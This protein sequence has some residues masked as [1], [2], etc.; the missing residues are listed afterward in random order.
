MVRKILG[1]LA[2]L[3]VGVLV[4]WVIEL[5]GHALYPPPQGADPNQSME[6]ARAYVAGLPAAALVIP[7]VAWL[8]GTLVGSWLAAFVGRAAWPGW[9]V[10]ALM[11]ASSIATLVMIPHPL[12]FAAAAIVTLPVA[13][14]VGVKLGKPKGA[15]GAVT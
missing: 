7:L 14:Y 2:G 12:W 5:A 3:V 13:S 9:L 10:A 8:G 4:I 1:S 15:P 11:V 6:A